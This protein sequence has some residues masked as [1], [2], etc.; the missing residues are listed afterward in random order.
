[1]SITSAFR[2]A[3]NSSRS[4]RDW[5]D[6]D[7][8]RFALAALPVAVSQIDAANVPAVG[9]RWLYRTLDTIT[10]RTMPWRLMCDSLAGSLRESAEHRPLA[11][12]WSPGCVF[13]D[14]A[15]NVGRR[16]VTRAQ[17]AALR[18]SP[19]TSAVAP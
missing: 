4:P 5:P 3:V 7:L 8:A 6:P 13:G 14:Q 2:T 1:M 19:V 15:G 17:R 16:L 12:A 10:P 11:V 18:T 9:T